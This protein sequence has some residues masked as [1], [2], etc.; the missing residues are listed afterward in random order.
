MTQLN[1]VG[2]VLYQ[3]WPSQGKLHKSGSFQFRW[4][5]SAVHSGT[6][7]QTVWLPRSADIVG[8]RKRASQVQS[9]NACFLN[10]PT[11]D[12]RWS[13]HKAPRTCCLLH[14]LP[15]MC[16]THTHTSLYT[17]RETP[18]QVGSVRVQSTDYTPG[19]Q[20]E[21]IWGGGGWRGGDCQR[22]EESFTTQHT[23]SVC[24]VW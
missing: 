3:P 17:R 24:S 7:T 9:W 4:L 2:L 23:H 6:Q 21:R 1:T 8:S 13:F 20:Q 19:A 18:T 14:P 11:E 16:T 22:A 5:L 10:V 12:E 15:H